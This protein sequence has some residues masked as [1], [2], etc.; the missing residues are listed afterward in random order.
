MEKMYDFSDTIFERALARI[1]ACSRGVS[2]LEDMIA[3]DLDAVISHALAVLVRGDGCEKLSRI[4]RA[5]AGEDNKGKKRADKIGA[6]IARYA[7]EIM[8]WQGQRMIVYAE[9]GLRYICRQADIAK[10][11][12][13]DPAS[14]DKALTDAMPFSAWQKSQ[15]KATFQSPIERYAKARDAL[16]TLIEREALDVQDSAIAR[17]LD[18]LKTAQ[19]RG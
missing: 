12:K 10:I 2:R 5:I 19:K 11:Y 6:A 7:H 16:A 1:A 13:K 17:L 18:A 4:I 3:S 9:K 8:G 14:A 15:K